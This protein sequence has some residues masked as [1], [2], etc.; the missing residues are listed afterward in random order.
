MVGATLV[1]L[2]SAAEVGTWTRRLAGGARGLDD[3]ELIDLIRA[4]EELKCA[5][6]GAQAEAT[7]AFDRSQRAAAARR[8]VPQERQ[9]RGIPEQVALAR[10]ESPHRGK[11]HVGLAKVLPADCPAPTRRSGP[12]ASASGR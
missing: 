11:R 5:A 6:E 10:R 2:P 7:A 4:L 9:G 12:A 1:A 3:A 8:G